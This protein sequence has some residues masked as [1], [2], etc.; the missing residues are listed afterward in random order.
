MPT[1]LSHAAES[2]ARIV[3]DYFRGPIGT[4]ESLVEPLAAALA[5]ASG[6]TGL[7]AAQIDD[8]VAPFASN[9]REMRPVPVY[10]AGFIVALD[11]LRDARGHLAWWQASQWRKLV[12]AAQSVNKERIDYS[13]L[14]WYR[15][16]EQT[17]RSHVAGPYVDYLCSD[18]YTITIATPVSIADEFAGVLAFD[19]LID[20]VEHQLTPRLDALGVDVTLVNG[21][22]RVVISTDPHRVTGDSVRGEASDCERVACE[23]VALDVLVS[24]RSDP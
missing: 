3:S 21:V 22:G 23:A 13:E 8:I 11:R 14:E 7:T 4:L 20:E 5:D 24:P 2:A 6:A 10:G 16:P 19:L 9:L 15:V 18:E 17:G 1:T 12:L